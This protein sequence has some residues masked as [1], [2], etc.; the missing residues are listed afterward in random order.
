MNVRIR[1]YTEESNPDPI[2]TN[3]A[4]SLLLEDP[5]S[6]LLDLSIQYRITAGAREMERDNGGKR[7]EGDL[8]RA[9]I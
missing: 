4:H 9:V 2:N 8:E 3:T 1:K 6:E 5:N 7:E